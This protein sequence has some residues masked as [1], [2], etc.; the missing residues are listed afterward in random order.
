MMTTSPVSAPTPFWRGTIRYESAK[1]APWQALRN[2]LGVAAPLAIG[3]AMGH[4][5]S[6]LIGATGALN[7]AFSD[8]TDP[9]RHRLRRMLT[10][11][12]ACALAVVAGGLTGHHQALIVPLTGACGFAAGM[13]VALGTEATDIANVTLVTLIVFSAQAMTAQQ[14]APAGLAALAGGLLQTI[15]ALTFWPFRRYGP[16]R[17]VLAHLYRRLARM[18][19]GGPRVTQAPPA[20]AEMTQA[21]TALAALAGDNSLEA[22]RC[23]ALL[24]QAERIR[25][26]LL[27]LARLRTRIGREAGAQQETAALDRGL[28]IAGRVLTSVGESFEAR[29]LAPAHR[30]PHDFEE[31]RALSR[32]L[33]QRRPPTPVAGMLQDARWQLDA[34][35]GQ[36]RSALELATHATPAG[37][38]QF[39]QR[40]AAQPWTLRLGGALAVLRANL[41]LESAVFRHAVRLAVSLTLGELVAH[42]VSWGR[43]YWIPMTIAIVL[44]PDFTTTFSRG[45]LRVA[46]TLIGLGLATAVFHVLAPAGD[47]EVAL[48]ALFAFLLRCFGPAN[49]GLFAVNLTALAVLM[50]AATG[51]AP[52]PVIA[53]RGLNTLAGGVIALVAYQVWPTWER[54][55]APEAV[56]RMLEAYR[57]YFQVV[58]DAY[59]HP[60]RPL[61]AELDR[62]RQAARLARSNAEASVAR[63]AA[64]PRVSADRVAALHRMLADSHRFIHAVMSLEAG[65]VRSRPVP[66][67][68]EFHAFSNHV[69]AT[70][71]YL[72]AALRGAHLTPADLH[73]LREDHHALLESADPHVDRYALVN[74]E[75]DRITN[76]LNTLAGEVLGEKKHLATDE[77]G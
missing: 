17:R 26:A 60:D 3:V 54:T 36:L 61:G 74:V 10:A 47:L 20:S 62:T 21:Q 25:L 58:R 27:A 41:T 72:A 63:L 75:A 16:E 57:I 43:P 12:L 76:S 37:S 59:L 39:E 38:L 52:G 18:A 56:A 50:F 9:Y 64:E 73:D 68:D 45:V 51:I 48:I 2:A 49:Y 66:A 13:M 46:G 35:A 19:S 44:R 30:H 55:Q 40:E 1:V 34:L 22:E 77:H 67:R 14:A 29:E 28:E 53:A 4:A 33:R 8:G 31:L 24:S 32:T 5:T 69:D 15:L 7:V 11:S 71:Y 65:L 42:S 70:L 6:G 23:L